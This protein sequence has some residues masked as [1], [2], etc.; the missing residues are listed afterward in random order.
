MLDLQE[1]TKDY[2]RKL[3]QL[4][5]AYARGEVSIEEVDARVQ[6][7]MKELGQAR[8]EAFAYLWHSLRLW[9]S[10]RKEIILGLAM[11]GII[12]YSWA[13]STSI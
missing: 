11:L 10:E 6:L 12:T 13:V 8:R 9:C 5:A 2:W 4:E 1:A 7:L 3:N